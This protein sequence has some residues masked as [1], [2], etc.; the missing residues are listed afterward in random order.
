MVVVE[1]VNL[2]AVSESRITVEVLYFYRS[3]HSSPIYFKMIFS[4]TC[5]IS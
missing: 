1:V 4:R 3:L 5:L 2:S